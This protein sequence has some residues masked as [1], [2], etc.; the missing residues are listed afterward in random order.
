MKPL[1]AAPTRSALYGIQ[2]N[3]IL[4]R[5]SYG[6]T[7]AIL[8]LK[9]AI[10]L[11]LADVSQSRSVLNE[12]HLR[13]YTSSKH[14]PN[15]APTTSARAASSWGDLASPLSPHPPLFR[16]QSR[17]SCTVSQLLCCGPLRGYTSISRRAAWHARGCPQ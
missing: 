16:A 6:A 5:L 3:S 15:L 1:R 14:C 11:I 17:G 4:R 13:Y 8:L 2:N 7:N 10:C 9:E 12:L